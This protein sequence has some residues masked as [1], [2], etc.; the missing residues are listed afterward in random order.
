M[1]SERRDHVPSFDR[2]AAGVLALAVVVHAPSTAAAQQPEVKTTVEPAPAVP[3]SPDEVS[4][5]PAAEDEEI[6]NRLRGIY[7]ATPGWVRDVS[8]EVD[9]GVVLLHGVTDDDR[10]KQWAGEIARKT[11][12]VVAVINLIAVSEPPVLDFSASMAEA[13]SIWRQFVQSLP[14]TVISLLGLVVTLVATRLA[15]RLAR[16]HFTRR[17]ESSLLAQM[18]GNASA[19]P[20]LVIG[21][22]LVLRIADLTNLA[23]TVLGGTGLFGLVIGIAFRDIAENY[24][25]SILIS[26][27]RP[28]RMG[29]T[30]EAAGVTGVVQAVT[31]RGTL[32]ITF[33]GN[34]VLIPN[35][36]IYKTTVTNMT[37]NPKIRLNFL[38]GIGAGGSISKAQQLAFEVLQAHEAILNEPP[39]MVLVEEISPSSVSLRIYMWVDGTTHAAIKVKS[40][41]IRLVRRAFIDAGISMPVEGREVTLPAGVAVRIT[42]DGEHGAP[43]RVAPVRE[44]PV[45]TRAS[46]TEAEAGLESEQADIQEQARQSEFPDQGDDLLREA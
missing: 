34:H 38:V 19:I 32:V 4:V 46:F 15:A 10:Y 21:I 25:A 42:R 23:I 9:Q 44:S 3:A 6:A 18:L 24:L 20:I 33:D 5:T 26:T 16:Y 8:V 28:F 27:R 12:D 13:R 36:L 37:A 29:D 17:L 40:A 11:Q 45:E 1:S 14:R 2:I 43:E 35:S 31:T 7:A 41:V 30:I 39:P 22:Y